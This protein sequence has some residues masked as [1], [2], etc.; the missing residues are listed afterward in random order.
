M[1]RH[2]FCIVAIT[3]PMK[4]LT[5]NKDLYKNLLKRFNKL[6]STLDVNSDF[7]EISTHYN[8]AQ[9]QVRICGR[10]DEANNLSW[11]VVRVINNSIVI[12]SELHTSTVEI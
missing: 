2:T 5:E 12:P 9:I 6:L 4:I 8:G 3:I 7:L 11:D 10:P 1:I